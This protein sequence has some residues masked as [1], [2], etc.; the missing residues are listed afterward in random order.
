M[1]M[2]HTDKV[3]FLWTMNGIE[4]V[5]FIEQA[6]SH[7]PTKIFTA[8]VSEMEKKKHYW[9]LTSVKV[10]DLKKDS[11]LDVRTHL[12]PLLRHFNIYTSPH[13]TRRES[14][15]VHQRRSSNTSTSKLL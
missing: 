1:G 6:N 5:E 12:K 14:K 4:I 3:F 7:H 15:K 2:I 9:I 11:V 8:E 10:N 13:P